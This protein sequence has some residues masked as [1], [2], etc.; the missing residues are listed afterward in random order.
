VR[1]IRRGVKTPRGVRR[2]NPGLSLTALGQPGNAPSHAL[3]AVA[4]YLDVMWW[5]APEA[6]SAPSLEEVRKKA[7]ILVIDDQTFPPERLFRRDGYHIKRWP[8]I[9]NLSQLTDNFFDLVLLDLHGVGL[10]ESPQRGGLGILQ[11]IKQRSPTQLVIA[12]SAQPWNIS[13]RDYFALADAVLDKG[14]DYVDFKE[15]VDELLLRRYSVG[16]FINK[17]NQELGDAAANAPKAVPKALRAI[18]TGSTQRLRRYLEKTL[19]E[20]ATVDRVIAIIGIAA[21]LLA[22]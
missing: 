15:K 7:N 9:E 18:R 6:T 22:A 8:K 3:G 21:S 14:V 5:S 2:G 10:A 13:N 11:H 17:M 1:P 4:R 16:Y 12:Y 19:Q 20:P